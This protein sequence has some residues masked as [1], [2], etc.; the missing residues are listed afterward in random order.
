MPAQIIHDGVALTNRFPETFVTGELSSG[1]GFDDSRHT[2]VVAMTVM[3][4]V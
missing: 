1:C 3:E 2:M 4:I